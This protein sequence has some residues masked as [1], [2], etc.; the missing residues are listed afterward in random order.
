[1]I[2]SAREDVPQAVR[3]LTG[4]KMVDFC[5]EAV[6]RPEALAMSAKLP[7]RQGRLYVFGVPHHESQEFPWFHTITNELE[8]LT[9]MGPECMEYFQTAVDMLVEGRVDLSAM[10]TPRMP[11]EQAA[12]AFRMYA[13]P[14]RVED[15]LKITLVL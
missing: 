1:V 6:G 12:E 5:V 3:E 11:W 4:G 15:A 8:L 2:D 9:S 10:V 14:S 7:R 13:D